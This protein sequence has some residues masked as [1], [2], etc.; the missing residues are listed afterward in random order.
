MFNVT[1]YI[2][3]NIKYVVNFINERKDLR[4]RIIRHGEKYKNLFCSMPFENCT[5]ESKGF[6]YLCCPAWLPKSIGNVNSNTLREVWNSKKAQKIRNSILDG[7]FQYCIEKYCPVLSTKGRPDFCDIK[8]QYL[9]D[10]VSKKMVLLENGA[11]I[12]ELNYDHTCNLFCRSC[13]TKAFSL[14]GEDLNKARIIQNKIIKPVLKD[15][16]EIV[17]TGPGDPLAS[18]LYR[19][20]LQNLDLSKYPQLR[21]ELFTK[22]LLLTSND[23]GQ[24]A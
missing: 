4:A 1:N 19:E 15:I 17:V 11:K 18:S 22:G 9:T 13:R 7:S 24:P 20:F 5:I 6:V 23:V 3:D 16:K 8:G 12:L 10:I 21:I 14:K 2:K